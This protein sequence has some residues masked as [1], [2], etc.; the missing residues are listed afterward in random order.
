MVNFQPISPGG[1]NP[2]PGS[3]GV[4]DSDGRFTLKTVE[5]RSHS[6]AVVGKHTVRLQYRAEGDE[7]TEGVYE[8]PDRQPLPAKAGDGTLTFEVPAAGTDQA[9][10]EL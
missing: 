10:F 4:T 9:N 3:A 1:A 5:R 8:T 6:G 7:S 2:G